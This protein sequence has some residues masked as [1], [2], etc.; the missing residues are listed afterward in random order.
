M[1]NWTDVKG[2]LELFSVDIERNGAKDFIDLTELLGLMYAFPEYQVNDHLLVQTYLKQK[3]LSPMVFWGRIKRDILPILSADDETL[4]ALGC[5]LPETRNSAELMRCLARAL[6]DN[7][8]E[9]G[10]EGLRTVALNVKDM[11]IIAK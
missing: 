7:I 9:Q 1:Q 4:N 5:P 6:A 8:N 10:R 11:C 2:F 3:K